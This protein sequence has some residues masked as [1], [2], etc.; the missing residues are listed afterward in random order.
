MPPPRRRSLHG[1]RGRSLEIG[2][3]SRRSVDE[4]FLFLSL[5][6]AA[7]TAP[8]AASRRVALGFVPLPTF[9]FSH[10]YGTARHGPP[11]PLGGRREA[12]DVA[13]PTEAEKTPFSRRRWKGRVVSTRI[14]MSGFESRPRRNVAPGDRR[15]HRQADPGVRGSRVPRASS[16]RSRLIGS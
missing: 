12:S 7:R 4:R 16:A 13:Y 5:F 14:R 6:S 8:E 2:T 9:L 11:P 15:A 3:R 1:V 10:A